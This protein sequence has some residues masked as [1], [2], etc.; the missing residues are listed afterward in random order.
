MTVKSYTYT[1]KSYNS[2]LLSALPIVLYLDLLNVP[3]KNKSVLFLAINK[4]NKITH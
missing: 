3:N 2:K 4:S 1:V